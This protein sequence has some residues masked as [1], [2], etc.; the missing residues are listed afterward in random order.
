MLL[1]HFNNQHYLMERGSGLVFQQEKL[2]EN[3]DKG[4][5]KQML[6][7]A[8]RGTS[9]YGASFFVVENFQ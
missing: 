1:G 5:Q 7:M 2:I 6:H 9:P 3:F 8:W 4:I